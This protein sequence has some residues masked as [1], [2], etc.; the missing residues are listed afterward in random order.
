MSAHTGAAYFH[1]GGL[2]SPPSLSLP[3]IASLFEHSGLSRGFG[4]CLVA[5]R[6]QQP[7]C[8]VMDFR[9]SHVSDPAYCC[10]RDSFDRPTPGVLTVLR[11]AG[12]DPFRR[13]RDQPGNGKSR[14]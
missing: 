8:V 7:P 5:L 13:F 6:F 2:Y 14:L 10:S 11:H 3:V 12:T 1:H 9:G 4:D